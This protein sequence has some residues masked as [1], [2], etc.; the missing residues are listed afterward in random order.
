MEERAVRSLAGMVPM[1]L[2]APQALSWGCRSW[3]CAEQGGAAG[4]TSPQ[5]ITGM[6]EGNGTSVAHGWWRPCSLNPDWPCGAGTAVALC[7]PPAGDRPR[8]LVG[9]ARKVLKQPEKLQNVHFISCMTPVCLKGGSE[10][11]VQAAAL[12]ELAWSPSSSPLG[13]PWGTVLSLPQVMS[14]P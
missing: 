11:C 7:S 14:R 4:R 9:T 1:C 8:C 3:H 5:I 6:A 2:H 12:E 10:H 13:A